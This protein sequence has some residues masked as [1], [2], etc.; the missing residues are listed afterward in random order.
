MIPKTK[1]LIVDDKREN[2][3]ALESLILSS[4]VEILSAMSGQDAL[5]LL[6]NHEFGL[7]ILDVQMPE[8]SGFDLAR[9]MRTAG[10]SKGI[11][12][13]FVTASQGTKSQIFE[14]YDKGAVD[15]LLKPLDPQVVRSKVKVFVELD[16][17]TKALLEKSKDLELKL[18]EMDL[19]RESAELANQAKSRFIANISHEIRTPLGAVLGYAELLKM[20]DQSSEDRENFATAIASNG[21][22]LL[23]LVDEILDL[24]K[25][26]AEKIEVQRVRMSLAQLIFD[27]RA[28]HVNRALDKS[29]TLVMT[30]EGALPR[31]IDS[32]PIR[33][34]QILNNIIGNALKFTDHGS[35]EVHFRFERFGL[36][37][38]IRILVKDSGCGIADKDAARLFQPFMQVDSS[39]KRQYGGTGLGLVI[40]R[41]LAK[42]LGG[43]VVLVDSKVGVGS[44]FAITIDVGPVDASDLLDHNIVLNNQLIETPPKSIT[45]SRLDDVNVL[46]VDDAID[47]RNLIRRMLNLAGAKV[48]LAENGEEAIEKALGESFDVI[49]MDLQMPGMDGYEATTLLRSRG[50]KRPIIALTAHT[51]KEDMKRCME[52]GFDQHLRKPVDREGL[53]REIADCAK[54]VRNLT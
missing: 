39:S 36:T 7:A 41:Q 43:D 9:L 26:E 27:L 28:V 51:M 34:K 50:Y 44:T 1:I 31:Y 40:S 25:V 12:I 17:K 33:L 6:L 11:P 42:L 4:D 2:I 30:G 24:A 53:L 3:L 38:R 16:Q 18:K 8:M 5:A 15:Y 47:N 13:I 20:P 54:R 10:R 45:S 29:I 14:G 52:V 37:N 22:V 23:K 49:L 35:V 46:V 21:Q 32:D 48:Q 19:L